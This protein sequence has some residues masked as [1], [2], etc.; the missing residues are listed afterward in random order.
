MA[1]QTLV[2]NTYDRHSDNGGW[3][4]D[5]RTELPDSS[6][7]LHVVLK[8]GEEKTRAP[9]RILLQGLFNLSR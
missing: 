5:L 2:A 6:F 9:K 8:Y 1:A 3:V 7:Y 4:A